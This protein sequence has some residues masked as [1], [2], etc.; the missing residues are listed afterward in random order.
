MM[1]ET[2]KSAVL[3]A[4]QYI[5]GDPCY[6]V[7][8]QGLWMSLLESADFGSN[9]HVYEAQH[10]Q[11]QFTAVSTLYG[12]GVYEDEQGRSYGVDAGL[13][14]VTPAPNATTAPN[15]THLVHFD[16]PFQVSKED[17]VITIGNLTIDTR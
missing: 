16:Q 11:H 15:G 4:G 8:E 3:P 14:G 5:V 10:K 17:G 12:D 13:I 9:P 2:P 7:E 1:N 6:A